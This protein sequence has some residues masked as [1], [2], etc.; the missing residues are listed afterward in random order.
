MRSAANARPEPG[1]RQTV[2]RRSNPAAFLVALVL[3]VAVRPAAAEVVASGAGGFVSQHELLLLAP[4][5]RVYQALTAEVHAWWDSAHSYSGD[6]A[7]FYIEDRALGCFC[8]KLPGG[9]VVA[10]M[11]VVFANPGKLLRLSG[12]LGPLQDIGASGTMHF[13]LEPA[14]GGTRLSYRYVV[15][16]FSVGGMAEYAEPVDQVQLGQLMRL[17]R[18]VDAVE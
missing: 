4:P 14:E 3:A 6:A 15:A 16:G 11:Q 1:R 18:Y 8:E 17:K 5:E 2:N 10:H 12:G 9:G 13:A 7:N